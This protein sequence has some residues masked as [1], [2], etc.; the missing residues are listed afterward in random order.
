MVKDTLAGKTVF[1]PVIDEGGL[2]RLQSQS[3]HFPPT[4]SVE[5]PALTIEEL[6]EQALKD[7][8]GP[9]GTQAMTTSELRKKLVFWM[10]RAS[11]NTIKGLL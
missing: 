3:V 11:H 2:P 6:A 10:Q 5:Y 1:R 4:I 9:T 7:I 8:T